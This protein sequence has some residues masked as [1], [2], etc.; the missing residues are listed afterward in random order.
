MNTDIITNYT[1]RVP[2]LYEPVAHE[3]KIQNTQP[4]Q[5]YHVWYCEW[6]SGLPRRVLHGHYF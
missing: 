6:T 3:A 1:D 4:G 5:G 2:H